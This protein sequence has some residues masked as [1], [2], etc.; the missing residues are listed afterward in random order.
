M[1]IIL[2]IN[3]VTLQQ[4]LLSYLSIPS[5]C[6]NVHHLTYESSQTVVM[7]IILLIN[8]LTLRQ[9][10]L[11]YLSI[12]SDCSNVHRLIYQSTHIGAMFIIL[13]VE[14]IRMQVVTVLLIDPA[15]MW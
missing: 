3:P 4:C 8:P 2:L 13:L 15:K 10:L 9:C 12:P 5:D 1:F 11:S 14:P 6:S 7:F